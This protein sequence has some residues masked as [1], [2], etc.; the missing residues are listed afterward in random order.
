[1]R[2]FAPVA[3]DDAG[4]PA[5]PDA[6]AQGRGDGRGA[7]R[8]P[9]GRHQ[10]GD[11][12][13]RQAPGAARRAGRRVPEGRGGVRGTE[14]TL[15]GGE[16]G[17]G[18][19]RQEG[20]AAEA[21]A[22]E[23][24]ATGLQE[25]WTLA[26]ERFDIAIRQKKATVQAVEGIKERL[27]SDQAQ[28]DRLEGKVK[29]T[30]APKFL[31]VENPGQ[32]ATKPPEAAPKPPVAADGPAAK[33]AETPSTATLMGVPGVPTAEP[34]AAADSLDDAPVVDLNTPAVRRRGR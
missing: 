30:A 19:L 21:V 1:M 13:A 6:D 33:P 2:Q 22:A 27:A 32:A 4:W 3:A 23:A 9:A 29:P 17:P 26:K 5:E 12:G 24:E 8:Q 16:G 14:H 34:N 28:L 25:E 18:T 10:A 11:G 31:Q 15:Q 20:K 7:D